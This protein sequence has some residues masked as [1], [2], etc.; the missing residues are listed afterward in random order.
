MS[1]LRRQT[2]R[3]RMNNQRFIEVPLADELFDT[4]EGHH[5]PY[6]IPLGDISEIVPHNRENLR[7]HTY[8]N[9]I[10]GHLDD[11]DVET[12]LRMRFETYL[13]RLREH[14][15]QAIQK[16]TLFW[17]F[18]KGQHI[19]L[20]FNGKKKDPKV[21]LYTRLIVPC[22]TLTLCNGCLHT[23][24][25]PHAHHCENIVRSPLDG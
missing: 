1:Y 16:P 15:T 23:E 7:Y 22:C 12:T 13:R 4:V 24:G 6:A 2:R 20:E 9:T 3:E 25:E 18:R 17:R 21:Q 19:S 5:G 14:V 8:V 10:T 11:S